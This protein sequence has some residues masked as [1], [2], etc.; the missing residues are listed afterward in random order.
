MIK[1]Y[2]HAPLVETARVEADVAVGEVVVLKFRDGLAVYSEGEPVSLG[3][4]LQ[5]VGRRTL[6]DCVGGAQSPPRGF[7][8]PSRNWLTR[9]YPSPLTAKA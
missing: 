6:S 4:Y 2:N 8:T 5:N 7:R 3:R 1:L 9:K